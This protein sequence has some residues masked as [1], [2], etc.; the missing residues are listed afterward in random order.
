MG[1]DWWIEDLIKVGNSRM[2][3]FKSDYIEKMGIKTEKTEQRKKKDKALIKLD[4]KLSNLATKMNR[5]PEKELLFLGAITGCE[6]C[7]T[8]VVCCDEFDV[9]VTKQYYEDIKK[10]IDCIE[11]LYLTS[12]YERIK[13]FNVVGAYFETFEAFVTFFHKLLKTIYEL[14]KKG[15][16]YAIFEG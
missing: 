3:Y 7:P 2:Q 11:S 12:L 9:G 6:I 16:Y 8:E 10:V 1:V 15:E 14:Y 4:N 13:N 5:Y